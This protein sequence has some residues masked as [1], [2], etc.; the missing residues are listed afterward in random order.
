M[1][2]EMPETP[3]GIPRPAPA[4]RPSAHRRVVTTRRL[5]LLATAAMLAFAAPLAIGHTAAQNILDRVWDD[6]TGR[7][8]GGTPPA[9][10]TP[11]PPTV[12]G[13]VAPP[14]TATQVA[15]AQAAPGQGPQA[16]TA[17]ARAAQAPAAEP[18]TIPVTLPRVQAVSETMTVTGNAASVNTVKLVA[19]VVGYL[20]QKNVQDGAIVRKG[21]LLYTIQQAQW[22]AQLQQAQASLNKAQAALTHARTEVQRYGALVKR[23]AATQTELDNWVYQRAAAEADVMSARAQVD[24][25]NLNL[26]YTEVRAPFDGQMGRAVFDPGNVVGGDGQSA[27][28]SEILQLDP[29]YVQ[30]N[31]S[32]QQAEQVRANLDQRRLTFEQMQQIPIEVQLPGETAFTHRGTLNYVAPAIDPATG[33]LFVRGILPNPN[34]DLLP[35]MFVNV[36]MP[37][38]RTLQ[39]ALLVPQRALQE[40][41]GGRYL[42]VVDQDGVVRQRYVQLGPAVGNWQVAT[43]GVTRGD[44]IVVGELW[45]AS[46]GTRVRPQTTPLT[47]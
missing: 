33:T 31:I 6:L 38:G 34:R 12:P 1:V 15:P 11:A 10:A 24:L 40:D 35:G 3:S 9:T 8:P 29:I 39:S 42:L 2:I 36:R 21:D 43:G 30:V 18:P 26:G 5:R 17:P 32:T 19:R 14:A 47:D 27:T 20:E 28:I 16:Q 44:R 46:P 4:R 25:A 13:P 37:L 41:Q 22:K 7:H 45:R 23:G